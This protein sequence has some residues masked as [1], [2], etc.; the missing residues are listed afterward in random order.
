MPATSVP[1]P[2][3]SGREL[4]R[5]SC[6]ARIA[7]SS[8]VAG[9]PSA[10]GSASDG[11]GR[12]N[13]AAATGQSGPTRRR[14]SPSTATRRSSQ[15]SEQNGQTTSR[16]TPDASMQPSLPGLSPEPDPSGRAAAGQ[17]VRASAL[18]PVVL[19]VG[20]AQ[21]VLGRALE[22]A[23]GQPGLPLHH[24]LDLARQLEIL[25]GDAL[26]VVA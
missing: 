6:A 16:A 2:P 15:P 17:S 26:V 20:E 18:G 1:R 3:N 10:D 22:G 19:D 13:P 7:A 4:A 21:V 8:T 23:A 9:A 11:A 24:L 5:R 14:P 12:P 25:I